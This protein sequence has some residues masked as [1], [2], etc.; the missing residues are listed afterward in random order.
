[1][2]A[3]LPAEPVFLG[4]TGS[5]VW[6]A[7]HV[8]GHAVRLIWATFQW[9]LCLFSIMSSLHFLF[10]SI[11]VIC[12]HF[13]SLQLSSIPLVSSLI[14]LTSL[15]LLYIEVSTSS[16]A[17]LL[18]SSVAH[19][20]PVMT[21]YCQI[22]QLHT[23]HAHAHTGCMWHPSFTALLTWLQKGA[24]KNGGSASLRVCKQACWCI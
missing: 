20:C 11:P 4:E 15:D 1:M 17:Y 14:F 23:Q 10:H 7:W 13:C 21:N 19:S 6:P 3:E 5:S 12:P 8:V 9:C 16:F 22:S 2:P 24:K 18:P